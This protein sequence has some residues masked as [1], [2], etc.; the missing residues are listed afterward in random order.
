MYSRATRPFCWNLLKALPMYA[1]YQIL[2]S[3]QQ[4]SQKA[5]N[6]QMIECLEETRVKAENSDFHPSAVTMGYSSAT[7]SGSPECNPTATALK[8]QRVQLTAQLAAS[9]DSS[10]NPRA[11]AGALLARCTALGICNH[12]PSLARRNHFQRCVQQDEQ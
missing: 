5:T 1:G 10:N 6:V 3:M 8:Q 11:A 4:L 12:S 9:K 7:T 2:S